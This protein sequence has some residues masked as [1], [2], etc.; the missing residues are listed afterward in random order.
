MS[1][2]KRK[3]GA[4]PTAGDLDHRLLHI[5][6][7]EADIR[8]S[9][10]S[11]KSLEA[12]GLHVGEALIKHSTGD[13]GILLDRYVGCISRLQDCTPGTVTDILLSSTLGLSRISFPRLLVL[14]PW[15]DPRLLVIHQIRCTPNIRFAIHSPRGTAVIVPIRVVRYPFGYRGHLLFQPGRSRRLPSR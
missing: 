10:A 7:Y 15:R 1:S 4:S 6:A 11:A 5:Q 8:C 13:S 14:L 12:N 2:R 3:H 9:P